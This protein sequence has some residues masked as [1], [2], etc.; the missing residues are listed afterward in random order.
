MTRGIGAGVVLKGHLVS[1]AKGLAG[2]IGHV[3]VETV[4][5]ICGSCG[6]PCVEA[7]SSEKAFIDRLRPVDDPDIQRALNAGS[8]IGD[9]VRALL[10]PLE[11][12]RQTPHPAIIQALWHAGWHLGV[13]LAHAGS[14]LNPGWIVLG[15]AMTETSP[16]KE[17]PDWQRRKLTPELFGALA[18][19]LDD[20][21]DGYYLEPVHDW[22]RL[23]GPKNPTT[24]SVDFHAEPPT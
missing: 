14:L 23:D 8:S 15:G 13:A 24:T 10:R 5:P 3:T 4:G 7:R 21:G 17:V 16:F 22:A 6:R 19:V 9:R 1:G 12:D 20:C 18:K 2:E 11:D